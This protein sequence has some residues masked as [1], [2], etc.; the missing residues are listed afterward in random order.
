MRGYT[1]LFTLVLNFATL[2]SYMVYAAGLSFPQEMLATKD[3]LVLIGVL[4][5]LP[6]LLRRLRRLRLERLD[7]LVILTIVCNVIAFAL[8]EAPMAD[9]V[10]NFRRH[11]SFLLVLLIFREY[12][13]GFR[14]EQSY[15]QFLK[16]ILVML[17]AFGVVEYLLPDSF[18]NS[19]VGITA[20]WDALSVDPFSTATI[21]ENGRFYSWDLFALLGEV[22]RMVSFYFEPTTMAAFFVACLCFSLVGGKR[23]R[24]WTWLIAALGLLTISKFFALAVP[25]A[26]AVMA[27][28]NRLHKHLFLSFVMGCIAISASVIAL[29]IDAGALAHLRG[30]SSLLEIVGQNKWLGL[31]LGAGGNYAATELETAEIGTESGFGNVAAQLGLMSVVYIFLLNSLY[32]ML[33]ESYRRTG[34]PVYVTAIAALVCW[35]LSFFLSASSLGLSG[36]AFVFILIG[37]VLHR[38]A[39]AR[40]RARALPAVSETAQTGSLPHLPATA[41]T[42][43][44]NSP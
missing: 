40:R 31:G 10:F 29:E 39:A 18:W 36:N 37:S 33:L 30:I 23:E 19:F 34:D 43:L 13:T 35:T 32:V 17:W 25:L 4:L 44:P 26:L 28:R 14:S 42:G 11:V 1:I 16:P 24:F 15:F 5:V 9:R 21:G 6:S 3:L 12:G 7:W 38:D 2:A 8:S 41:A 22:R 27:L 20:Y